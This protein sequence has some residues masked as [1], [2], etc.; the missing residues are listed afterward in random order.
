MFDWYQGAAKCDVYLSDV[1]VSDSSTQAVWEPSF[2]SSRWFT[3]GWTLQELLAPKSVEF[4]SAEGRRLGNKESLKQ[5]L[6][7]IT[8]ISI[9]A[10]Q[11]RPLSDFSITERMMWASGRKTTRTEDMAYCLIGIFD[12]SMAVRYGEGERHA[13]SRLLR[14]VQK[15]LECKL[16]SS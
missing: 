11:G 3:R 7:E 16:L 2:R 6:Y 5:I 9:P 12:I 15:T 8:G 10:I 1:L 13:R 14:K 4:F